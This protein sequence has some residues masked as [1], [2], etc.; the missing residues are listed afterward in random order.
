MTIAPARPPVGEP[1][2]VQRAESR[3]PVSQDGQSSALL[4]FNRPSRAPRLDFSGALYSEWVKLRSLRSTWLFLGLLVVVMTVINV[5]LF[6]FYPVSDSSATGG[7]AVTSTAR[8]VAQV[9]IVFCVILATLLSTSEFSSGLIYTTLNA[10]PRRGLLVGAKAVLITVVTF[11]A[12]AIGTVLSAVFGFLILPARGCDQTWVSS[13]FRILVGGCLYVT[14][15]ALIS[16][17]LGILLR[18]SVAVIAIVMGLIWILPSIVGLVGDTVVGEWVLR[19]LPGVAGEQVF[20]VTP[21]VAT[22]GAWGGFGILL[23]YLVVVAVAACAAFRRR[24]I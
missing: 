9:D 5:T 22:G 3:P 19:L 2:A 14:V 17:F 15:M 16:L 20:A 1:A 11:V 18:S 4:S 7:L 8:T 12:T 13:D 24:D 10:V 23:G 6:V 21:E